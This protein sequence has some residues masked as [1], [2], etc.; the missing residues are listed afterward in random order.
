MGIGALPNENVDNTQ[1]Y[2]GDANTAVGYQ[3]G[4]SNTTGYSNTFTG[5]R[6][7][8]SNTTGH[9]N[10]WCGVDAGYLNDSGYHNVFLGNMTGYSND[11]GY[12]NTFIN[13]EAGYST[14]S[15]YQNI[16]LGN[17][18]GY[19]NTIGHHNIFSGYQAGYSNTNGNHNL[20][21]GTE[22]G[23]ANVSGYDNIYMGREA[24]Y[25]STD[26]IYNVFLG[27]QA[28]RYL[29]DGSTAA[30]STDQSIFLGAFT[31]PLT[32]ND[33][34]SIILGYGA[35]GLGSNTV[36]LGNDSVV[37]TALKGNIG[38][39][40]TTPSHR[41]D[42]AGTLGSFYVANT[43]NSLNFTRNGENFIQAIEGGSS[44]ILTFDSNAYNFDIDGTRSVVVDGSG[45][46]GVGTSTPSSRLEVVGESFPVLNVVRNS[47]VTDEP[48]GTASVV[49]KTSGDMIDGFNSNC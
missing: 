42:V 10:F 13:N 15:G 41:L 3:A 26:G 32:A 4:Y 45:N 24:G 49:H 48:R 11:S 2:Y 25:A 35:V 14:T 46:V 19:L 31:K 7:G 21:S 20:F 44:A 6:A 28:G 17:R 18:A 16:F 40:T 8:Y 47:V 33:Q 37:T 36:V 5:Y 30:S 23:Y 38:I 9:G 29:T 22:A 12:H 34:N 43:G 1:S 27:I 39:G